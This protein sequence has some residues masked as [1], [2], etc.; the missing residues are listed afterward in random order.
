M[1]TLSRAVLIGAAGAV[2]TLGAG[3]PVGVASAADAAT[4]GWPQV[5]FDDCQG[6]NGVWI[7][8]NG[9]RSAWA[10]GYCGPVLAHWNG[11][12]WRDVSLPSRFARG[13]TEQAIAALSGSYAWTFAGLFTARGLGSYAL[14]RTGNRWQTFTLAHDSQLTSA[15]V[16]S[17]TS[18]WAFGSVGTAGYA[19]RFNGKTWRRVKIPVVPQATAAPRPDNIWAVGAPATAATGKSPRIFMLAHWTGQMDHALVPEPSPGIRAEPQRLLGRH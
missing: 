6:A 5:V 11:Q 10:S 9:P 3:I 8:A 1:R 17:R 7:T 2:L 12:S 13:F 18:A 16:F 15:V 4:P 14:L 19:I